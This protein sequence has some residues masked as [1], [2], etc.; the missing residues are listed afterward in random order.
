MKPLFYD[1]WS[2]YRS[3]SF[4][5]NVSSKIGLVYVYLPKVDKLYTFVG[6]F[7]PYCAIFLTPFEFSG[8]CVTQG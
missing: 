4:V 2:L 8:G 3:L 5:H 1:L 7:Y 6:M